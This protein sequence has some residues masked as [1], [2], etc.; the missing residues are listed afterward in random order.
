[1]GYKTSVA[2]NVWKEVNWLDRADIQKYLES[3]GFAVYDK[4]SDDELREAL[5][6][7]IR[8]GDIELDEKHKLAK[9]KPMS[10]LSRAIAQLKEYTSPTVT[11]SP[12][13]PAE[14]T[15]LTGKKLYE[16]LRAIV[17]NNKPSVIN[18]YSVSVS[19]AKAVIERVD[20]TKPYFR[21]KYLNLPIAALVTIAVDHISVIF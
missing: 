4:E 21:K 2:D 16:A 13:Y 12:N 9:K 5:V 6:E 1:M 18:D 10:H 20:S 17:E 15:G 11:E 3:A 19:D 8:S 7:A 14:P